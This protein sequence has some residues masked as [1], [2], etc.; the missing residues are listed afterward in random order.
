MAVGITPVG[1]A[2]VGRGTAG[3]LCRYLAICLAVAV[4]P[5]AQ[6]Q[7]PPAATGPPPAPVVVAE[8]RQAEVDIR[9]TFVG[10]VKP[11]RT[12]TVGSP[13]EGLV[14]ELAVEE[15][16]R[17][18]KGEKLAQLRDIQLQLQLAAAEAELE[19]RKYELNELKISLPEQVEQADARMMAA[20]AVKEFVALRLKRK[21][22]LA[23][24]AKGS[25]SED[26]VQEAESAAAGASEKLREVKMALAE[27]KAVLPVKLKRAEARVL[28]QRLEVDRLRD[29]I[30]L[31]RIVAPFD[32]YVTK[33]YTEVG[34]W[35][36]QG[37]PVVEM[38]QVDRVE[39][40]VS[41][42]EDYACRLQPNTQA[43]VT[44]GA[45]PGRTWEA[46]V[47]AIVPQAEL[48][49]RCFPVIVRLENEPG[50]G[51]ILLKPGMFARA[52]LL[53]AGKSQALLVR[54]DAIVLGGPTPVVI[55][56]GPSP[57]NFAQPVSV[58]LG[59][60]VG[61]WIE[62]FGTL[63]PGDR[64]V[65]EGNERLQPGQPLNVISLQRPPE[66]QPPKKTPSK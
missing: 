62:V 51:G 38:V 37:A 57:D 40:E 66:N 18:K 3:R 47:V 27:S 30:T 63:K 15:G 60:A 58:E 2:A 61:E 16:D 36:I 50:P 48:R 52:T 25:V 4:G 28:A 32:G 49:S 55:A 59:Q 54:K 44:V 65:I 7:G 56:V 12:S 19:I 46:P 11:L 8:V 33:E 39:V 21:K 23:V 42:P 64:V 35:L 41:V 1:N 5:A 17:V 10:T 14:I 43:T 26:E 22:K 31:N 29:D 20:K 34:Q 24:D 53:I 6:G 13:R 45:L 9:Q